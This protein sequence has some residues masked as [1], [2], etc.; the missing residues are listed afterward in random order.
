M[1]NEFRSTR[2]ILVTWKNDHMPDVIE[3]YSSLKNFCDSYPQYSYN[4]LNNH[5]SKLK[6]PFENISIKVERLP[7][8]NHVKPKTDRPA[9]NK[10]LFWEFKY[11][12][13]NWIA[14]YRTIIGRILE[15]GLK[16]EW[17]EMIRF[18]GKEKVVETIKNELNFLSDVV[19]A[20]VCQLFKLKK[21]N[22]KCYIRKRSLPKH[23]I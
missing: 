14:S 20:E 13:I 6:K 16:W 3:I 22:L 19:I 8:I 2:V 17:E 15:Q 9:V 11:D 1:K 23:W 12:E 21:E 5:I 4:T 10:A 7:L 18:Y